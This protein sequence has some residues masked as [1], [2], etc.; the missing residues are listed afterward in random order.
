MA[1]A[2]R[3]ADH[4][5]F[6]IAP[7]PN[8]W[9]RPVLEVLQP[10]R[11]V[12]VFA[13]WV[14][15]QALAKLGRRIGFVRRRDGRGLPGARPHGWFTAS[16]LLVR[17]VAR[18]KTAATL[19]N[20]VRMRALVDHTAAFHIARRPTPSL[21]VA[22]SL[23]AR[24]SFAHGRQ[25]GATCLLVEDLPDLDTLVDGLDALASAHPQA[26][27]LRNHRPRLRAHARQRAERWQA[28]AVCVRGRVAWQ[29]LG[30]SKTR[31]QL[32][33]SPFTGRGTPGGDVLFAGPP[34]AR[35]GSTALPELLDALEDV[36]VRVLPGPCSEPSSLQHH[37]RIQIHRGAGLDGVG[38][39]LSLSPLESHPST[40]TRALDAGVP[41]VGTTAST[42][43]VTSASI[44]C[45]D[46]SPPGALAEALTEAVHGAAPVPQPW[47]APRS[48]AQYIAESS[49]TCTRNSASTP[50][51]RTSVPTT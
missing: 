15:P 45:A 3:R 23:A 50:S 33:R 14:L 11:P 48:L 25:A 16:E 32:P 7:E 51:V 40:V 35:C 8:D 46:A 13:P 31:V 19:S 42:G 22:P 27:F 36:T 4:R 17:G 24:R 18:G 21:I 49:T 6:I 34:L 26:S 5:V 12:E 38:V 37:P 41:I 20:R 43:V 47:R 1:D 9:L 44:L 39:V 30:P 2:A 28:D 29:R 10:S